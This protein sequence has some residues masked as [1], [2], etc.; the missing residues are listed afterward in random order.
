MILLNHKK[1]VRNEGIFRFLVVNTREFGSINDVLSIVQEAV[2]KSNWTNTFS[3][4]LQLQLRNPPID[5]P[6]YYGDIT[7]LRNLR[8]AHIDV[9]NRRPDI[10]AVDCA[11]RLVCI[12]GS[13]SANQPRPLKASDLAGMKLPTIGTSWAPFLDIERPSPDQGSLTEQQNLIITDR[14]CGAPDIT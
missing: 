4:H 3:R 12:K 14:N 11:A 10:G 1:R 8:I 13:V 9:S 2:E 7:G 5:S 6:A